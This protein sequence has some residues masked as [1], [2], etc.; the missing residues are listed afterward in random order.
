MGQSVKLSVDAYP[1]QL[2]TGSI[3][4]ISSQVDTASRN[5][6]VQAELPNKR[7]LL[8]PGIFGRVTLMTGVNRKS[9]VVDADALTY[10]T[11][12]DYVY[13]TTLNQR[14]G[15]ILVMVIW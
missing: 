8:K 7:L 1:G 13:V 14:R 12:G 3:E 4:A 11:F 9:L 2:F 15:G 5:I 6:Q 10:N